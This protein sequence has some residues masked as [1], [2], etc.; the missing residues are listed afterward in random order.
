MNL[1][2]RLFLLATGIVAIYTLKF[3]YERYQDSKNGSFAN[4][5][6][7][8]SFAVLL[9]SGL[10]LILFGWN[11]LG[12]LGSGAP[13][14]LVAVVAT[15]IPFSL[16]TGL[17]SQYF[18]EYERSYLGT[19]LI[20]IILI[21][22]SRFIEL[23]VF[24]KIIYPL[25]HGIAGLTIFVLP[26]ILVKNERA[27]ASIYWI[28][29]GGT[30]IGLG[31]IALAFLSLGKQLLFFSPEF[32]LTILAP[33]LFLTSLAYMFGLLKGVSDQGKIVISSE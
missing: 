11:I 24:G 19:M 29:V 15:L 2:D 1:L 22:L 30:L 28:T 20:G 13:N 27:T 26:I 16:A 25:F 7:M 6:F 5:Y 33:L 3:V 32:V 21:T 31:G 23:G 14:R 17:V 12:L 18:P 9:I 4:V 8:I 10:L